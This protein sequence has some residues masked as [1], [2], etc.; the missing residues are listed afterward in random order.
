MD[1]A[2]LAK[3]EDAFEGY[4]GGDLSDDTLSSVIAMQGYFVDV[5]DGCYVVRM[6]SG[7]VAVGGPEGFPGRRLSFG[8]WNVSEADGVE[9]VPYFAAGMFT[10]L[11]P[12]RNTEFRQRRVEYHWPDPDIPGRRRLPRGFCLPLIVTN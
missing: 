11:D 7:N 10:C 12:D 9:R 8:R 2:I 6:R 5:K 1:E 4:V 3:L